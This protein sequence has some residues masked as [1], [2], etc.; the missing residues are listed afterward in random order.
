MTNE[1]KELREEVARLRERIAVLEARPVHVWPQ[2]VW[3]EPQYYPPVP[4]A[5]PWKVTCGTTAQEP[6]LRN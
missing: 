4:F 2:P 5:P 3:V 6:P 1:I